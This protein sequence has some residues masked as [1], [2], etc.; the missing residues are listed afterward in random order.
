MSWRKGSAAVFMWKMCAT[1]ARMKPWAASHSLSLRIESA[2]ARF[3]SGSGLGSAV[4]MPPMGTAPRLRHT[5]TRRRKML[6]MNGVVFTSTPNRSGH[7]DFGSAMTYSKTEA[8]RSQ[9]AALRPAA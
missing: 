9:R 2:A 1:Q 8:L 3:T 7:T 6:A 5:A 4:A